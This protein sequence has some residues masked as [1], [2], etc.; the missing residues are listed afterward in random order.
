[1]PNNAPARPHWPRESVNTA[2]S[3]NAA[4]MMSKC[5]R[6]QNAWIQPTR[7]YSANGTRTYLVG[8]CRELSFNRAA[9]IATSKASRSTPKTM[10]KW[11]G[12]EVK[13][14]GEKKR[15]TAGGGLIQISLGCAA[16][17]QHAPPTSV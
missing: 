17:C 2:P 8:G 10:Q 11:R 1:M 4:G 6:Y 14:T 12:F 15:S 3:V 13:P 16:P 9:L 7:V 5:F